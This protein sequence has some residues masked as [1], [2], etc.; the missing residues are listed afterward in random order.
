MKLHTKYQRPE[1][2]G[3]R[4]EDVLRF[5]LKNL[6]FSSCDLLSAMDRNHLNSFERG[7]PK[8]YSCE[9]WRP[10][11]LVSDKK[12]FEGFLYIR[13]CKTCWPRGRAGQGRAGQGRANFDPRAIT[14]TILLQVH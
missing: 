5:Q 7:Q 1:P 10:A 3:F 9:V 12:I 8:D 11:L 14:L 6:F 2:S 13:L 4:Q